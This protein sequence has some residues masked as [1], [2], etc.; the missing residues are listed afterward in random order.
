VLHGAGAFHYPSGQA[1][2]GGFS[3]TTSEEMQAT[4]DEVEMVVAGAPPNSM[5]ILSD[6]TGAHVDKAAAD[7]LKVVATKDRPHVRRSAFVGADDIP[8]IYLRN[9]ETF[10]VRHFPR[11]KSREEA[12]EWLTADSEAA[13]S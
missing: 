6:F 11:F 5:L 2:I 10:S 4:L 1:D 7:R 12:L 13:A 8:E 9:L 3:R